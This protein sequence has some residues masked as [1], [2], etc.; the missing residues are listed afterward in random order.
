MNT[1]KC[2]KC[3]DVKALT[4]FHKRTN[5][6]SGYRS[7]C[8]DCAK[9]RRKAYY[10]ANRERLKAYTAQYINDNPT[11]YNATIT[12][13]RKNN[14]EVI[15]Q[16]ERLYRTSNAKYENFK[17]KLTSDE[18]LK[19]SSDGVS[20][21][22]K[23]RY[24]GKYFIPTNLQIKKRISALNGSTCGEHSL[25]C[26]N[27]C[28]KACPV[29]NQT[30]YPKGFKKATSREVRSELRKLVLERDNWCCQ[31]CGKTIDDAQL[32]CHHILPIN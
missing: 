17:D 30:K 28:K 23:C 6:K 5:R 16:R 15:K 10:L 20:L 21:E 18:D 25:Y 9:L 26:S 31:K 27:G 24:C 1:K 8:K 3:K 4:E 12:K 29:F 11:K 19:L 7:E 32:H 13:Y 22:V 2:T 14:K